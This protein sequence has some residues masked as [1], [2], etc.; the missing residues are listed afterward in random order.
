MKLF[1]PRILQPRHPVED[2]LS[3]RHVILAVRH[4]VPKPLK[5]ELLVRLRSGARVAGWEE[6]LDGLWAWFQRN[7]S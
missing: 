2:R 4:K 7:D 1:P 3:S 6:D 5:L